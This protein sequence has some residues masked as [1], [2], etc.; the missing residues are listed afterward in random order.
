MDEV[1][2]RKA[3]AAEARRWG[4]VENMAGWHLAALSCPVSYDLVGEMR[5]AVLAS[6]TQ[7]HN[8]D[9]DPSSESVGHLVPGVKSIMQ[10]MQRRQ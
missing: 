6:G 3:V 9:L 1:L 8:P 4:I 10:L 5:T 2:E 7:R